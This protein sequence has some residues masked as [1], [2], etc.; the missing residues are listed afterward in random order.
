MPVADTTTSGGAIDPT[1][2]VIFASTAA[3][4]TALE[5]VST[6]AS[7]TQNV[8]VV[9]RN[10]AGSDVTETKAMNGTSVVSLS[11]LGTVERLLSVILA[12]AAAGTV[13]L[14]GAGTGT[15]RVTIPAGEKGAVRLFRFATV[16]TSSS[17]IFYEKFFWKNTNASLAL[18]D[19]T[20]VE[21]AGGQAAKI[22][23]ALEDAVN[24][25]TS[26]ANRLTAPGA[27]DIGASGFVASASLVM[28]TE[29]DAG[30]ADLAAASAIGVWVKL[31][32]TAGDAAF[33]DTWSC[34]VA[35]TST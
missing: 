24:D 5:I 14:R 13:T 26:V 16:P 12:S 28:A 8:V 34:Q 27:S 3:I 21:V 22:A 9:G 33:S 11:T 30:T 17:T 19:A 10:A 31:T 1:I 23:S 29:T 25:T 18:Q 2:R 15:T 7:D 4:N 6:S 20:V 35:G 32:L